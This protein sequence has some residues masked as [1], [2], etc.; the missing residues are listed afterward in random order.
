MHLLRNGTNAIDVEFTDNGGRI[1]SV[2]LQVQTA[3]HPLTEI[4]SGIFDGIKHNAITLKPTIA[5][6]GENVL[7]T[8]DAPLIDWSVY[9]LNGSLIKQGITSVI[10]T[11]GLNPGLYF[12]DG[13]IRP[14]NCKF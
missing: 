1:S 10:D 7:I 12:S 11:S 3:D 6:S 13:K 5:T 4:D 14:D 2:I 9:N 8:T